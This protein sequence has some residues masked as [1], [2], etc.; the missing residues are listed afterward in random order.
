MHCQGAVLKQNCGSAA[1]DVLNRLFDIALHDPH[2]L[3]FGYRPDCRL[4]G[5]DPPS[6]QPP[7]AVSPDVY[8]YSSLDGHKPDDHAPTRPP[9]ASERK[10]R[11]RQ[12][13]SGGH[14]A[15]VSHQGSSSAIF[16]VMLLLTVS[17]TARLR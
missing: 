5:A 10:E 16:P 11:I 7:A 9:S 14:S 6:S 8:S 15:A 17:T 13:E 2:Y 3:R 4:H 1:A 12:P